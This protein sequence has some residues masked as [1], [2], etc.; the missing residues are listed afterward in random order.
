LK[1]YQLL[2]D[3]DEHEHDEGFRVVHAVACVERVLRTR[4]G[5]RVA[6]LCICMFLAPAPAALIMASS[7][8]LSHHVERATL[9]G[10]P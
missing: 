10:H 3:G 5:Q 7:Q 6:A 1:Q 2:D 8:L 4:F 9:I